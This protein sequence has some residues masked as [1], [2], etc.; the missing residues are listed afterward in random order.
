VWLYYAH[1]LARIR[2][3]RAVRPAPGARHIPRNA[4]IGFV[5]NL[6]HATQWEAL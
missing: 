6:V 4:S 1:E 3:E 2:A 5:D